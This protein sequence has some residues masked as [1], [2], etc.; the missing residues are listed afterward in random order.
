LEACASQLRTPF[1]RRRTLDTKDSPGLIPLR[2]YHPL[3]CSVPGDFEFNPKGVPRSV[4]PHSDTISVPV[5]FALSRVQSPLLAGSQLISCPLLTKMLQFSRFPLADASAFAGS[6]I[7][8]SPVQRLHAP[9]RGVSPLGTTFVGF[10]AELFPNR[11]AAISRRHFGW[12]LDILIRT[13]SKRGLST[14]PKLGA[15]TPLL[16][17]PSFTGV[18]S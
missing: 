14:S 2:D 1:P 8:S 5:R 18:L 10:R 16:S 11:F 13:I 3:G 4:T 9:S 17:T 7:R 15:Y 6:P 12:R